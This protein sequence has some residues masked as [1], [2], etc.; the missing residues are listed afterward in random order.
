MGAT[1]EQR[2]LKLTF[3]SLASIRVLSVSGG[4]ISAKTETTQIL[5]ALEL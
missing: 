1:G 5:I 2:C 3:V 4:Q